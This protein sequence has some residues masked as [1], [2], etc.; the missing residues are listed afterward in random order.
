MFG[1][2]S[3]E[4]ASM[5]SKRADLT[6]VTATVLNEIKEYLVLMYLLPPAH[7]ISLSFPHYL[8]SLAHSLTKP[9]APLS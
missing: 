8:K 9:G 1:C 4:N 6:H 7:K 3:R 5:K 2:S